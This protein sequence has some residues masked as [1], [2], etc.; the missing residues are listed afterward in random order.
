MLVS[1]GSASAA[2]RFASPSGTA[3]LACAQAA[4]CDIVT[5][6]NSAATG[7][8]VTIEPGTYGSPVPL[9]TN[10]ADSG[11]TLNIHGAAGQA[12]P[13]IDTTASHAFDLFGGSTLSD[14]DVEDTS[15]SYSYGVYVGPAP[16]SID[17]V[18]LHVTGSG[19]I[20]CYENG[21]LTDSFCW[22]SGANGIAAT[23][24]V[25]NNTGTLR[26]DTL[27]ASGTGGI[28]VQVAATGSSTM[29]INL[30]NSI[31]HGAGTDV[32]ATASATATSVLTADHSNYATVSKTL[33]GGT[34]TIAPAGSG[35]N[36]TAPPIFAGAATG[37][38]HE[39]ASSP[40]VDHGTDSP[41]NGTTDL[42]GN[43]RD[44][45][46]HTDIGA[47]EFVSAPLCSNLSAATK[48]GTATTIQLHCQDP[49][50]APLTYA[51]KSPPAHGRASL[52]ASTGVVRY[53]PA[54]GYSGHDSFSY[55]GTS[56]HGTSATSTVSITVRAGPPPGLEKLKQSHAKW[57]EKASRKHG[58]TNLPVGTTF[59]FR[60]TE[61]A[62]VRLVFLRRRTGR[63]VG[64]LT[65]AGKSGLNR[66]KFKGRTAGHRKL[67]PGKYTV[68][69]S[70]SNAGGSSKR[71][72][73][74]F[75]IVG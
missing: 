29:T 73:L 9:T 61:S 36:Q 3:S 34:L 39:L 40:T 16:S 45:G 63:K 66:V 56:I 33:G 8:E 10:L 58:Q 46:S 68:V 26:N 15:P 55:K 32:F 13:V 52:A 18:I 7:D 20:A 30:I 69:I 48:F 12:R 11:R 53:T 60:L 19:S 5:A 67:P 24:L 54:A 14:V 41:L 38:V 75:T 57:L 35:T 17:H 62:R 1:A 28:G 65:A 27:I 49:V 22:S 51:I 2:A 25:A 74:N 4:P 43:P 23:A 72:R 42:D 64:T 31:A 70:A 47:Y 37:N 71:K 50:S 6:I 21:T 59:S 44:L